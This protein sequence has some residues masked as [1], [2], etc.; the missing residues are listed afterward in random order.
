M[1]NLPSRIEIYIFAQILNQF[2][3]RLTIF[4]SIETLANRL[5]PFFSITL[6]QDPRCEKMGRLDFSKVKTISAQ[7]AILLKLA[8][9]EIVNWAP[10]YIKISLRCRFKIHL[11]PNE[12]QLFFWSRINSL[13]DAIASPSHNHC[14]TSIFIPIMFTT[15]DYN[16]LLRHCLI[17]FRFDPIRLYSPFSTFLLTVISSHFR[18]K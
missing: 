4:L 10:F 14:I 8:L 13:V 15:L 17:K 11:E 16:I 2:F 3:I 5:R 1:F 6:E 7:N 18:P 12:K 9:A